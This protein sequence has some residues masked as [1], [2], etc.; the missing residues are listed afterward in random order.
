MNKKKV[1][2]TL[3]KLVRD[4]P[5]SFMHN[6]DIVIHQR[7]LN[8]DEFIIELKNKLIEESHEVITA[9]SNELVEEIAD[10]HEI[11]DALILAS[12]IKNETLSTIRQQKLQ[13]RGGFN[14]RLFISYIDV[15]IHSQAYKYCI[16]QPDKYPMQELE[17]I[18]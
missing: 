18:E 2:F 8:I 10:L 11:L 4:I 17:N 16:Q 3:N 14:K 5:S 1:R 12:K 6:P 9:N 13:K 15:P 7:I